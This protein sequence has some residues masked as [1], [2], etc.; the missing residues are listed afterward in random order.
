[1]STILSRKLGRSGIEVSAMGLGC[2]A[3]GG[4]FQMDGKADG[5]GAVDDAESIRAIHRAIDLGVTFF[6]TADAY[7]TGHSERILGQALAGRRPDVV[8]AT[9][10]GHTYDEERRELTGQDASPAYIRRACEA[11]LRRL[12]TDYLDLYQ[13][14]IWSLPPQQAEGVAE[15][16]EKLQAEGLIRAY[17]WS[18]D[19][20]TCSRLFADKPH[21]AAIQHNLNVFENARELVELCEQHNLAS[22]NRSPLAMGFLSGKFNAQSVLPADD[23]RG[24]GHEWVSYFH[25]G[26]PRPEFLERLEAVREIL[27]SNGRSLVQGALAWIWGRSE[28]TIPIPGFKTVAQVEENAGAMR[29]GPLTPAQMQEI[30][31]LLGGDN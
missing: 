9:K 13:L 21:C 3:I 22:I 25:E 6:D 7:G 29:F 11:S 8:I 24:S 23:V 15:T 10:F 27:T 30:E 4:P 17:G 19:D 5:W 2:W 1:M 20:L 14:H 31:A 18:T 28:Q 16:L 12:K 26:R